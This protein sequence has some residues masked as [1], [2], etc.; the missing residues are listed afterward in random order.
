MNKW[1][2]L[3]GG[4]G[5]T[6]LIVSVGVL[7]GQDYQPALVATVFIIFGLEF[8]RWNMREI[9]NQFAHTTQSAPGRKGK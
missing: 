6:G 2:R 3:Y 1:L 8:F 4:A 9:E 5:I 7:I